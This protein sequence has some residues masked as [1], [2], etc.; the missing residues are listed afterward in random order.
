MATQ[1]HPKQKVTKKEAEAIVG[2]LP[3]AEEIK[4]FDAHLTDWAEREGQFV[5]IKGRDV[6]GFYARNDDALDAGYARLGEGP[7][8][9]KQVLV[10]EPIYQLGDVEL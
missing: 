2:R 7:F 4:T 10:H 8:L 3:L 5:L 1:S 6:L 9:V